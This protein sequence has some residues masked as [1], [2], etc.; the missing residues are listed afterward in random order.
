[1]YPVQHHS[2]YTQFTDVFTTIYLHRGQ[3]HPLPR[4]RAMAPEA[5]EEQDQQRVDEEHRY[6]D[7]HLRK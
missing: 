5:R 4:T 6:E 1:M 3:P 7:V 2:Q